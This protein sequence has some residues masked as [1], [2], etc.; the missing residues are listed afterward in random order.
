MKRD[1]QKPFVHPSVPVGSLDPA[2]AYQAGVNAR[3]GLQKDTTPVAG[4][5]SPAI[6]RL[7]GTPG[8]GGG[9]T[10]EQ[11]A[12]IERGG[13][14]SQRLQLAALDL[15][16]DQAKKDPGFREGQ[17]SMMAS[18]Q[19]ELAAKYGVVR[20]GKFIPPQQLTPPNPGGPILRPETQRGLEKLAELAHAQQSQSVLPDQ[21]VE[22]S[23]G[24]T[25]AAR[26]GNLPGD[27]S[28]DPLSD[29]DRAAIKESVSQMDEF[30]FDTWRQAM[31]KDILNTEEQKKLVEARLQ[32]LHVEDLVVSL[33]IIQRVPII[34][35]KFEPAFKTT[36]GETDLGIKR[37]IMEDAKSL[38]VSDRYTLDKFALMSLC[39]ALHSINNKPFPT[40]QDG[41]GAFDD[42]LFRA[43][44]DAVLRLPLHML[45]SLG[46]HA[47]WFEQRVRLL[48]RAETLGNG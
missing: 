44:L 40:Y 35:G 47:F 33:E 19:P 32:P 28:S 27:N 4:G 37:L 20:Q 25:A 48:F 23:E 22:P 41:S 42:K 5:K 26:I 34:P 16:P 18:N 15:L 29:S 9:L 8:A 45:A 11:L 14:R 1:D 39:A 2:K 7:D 38:E 13:T 36:S 30:Q 17:G 46:V 21:A 31:M 3:R 6:P 24:A 43:K 10:M 12:Q